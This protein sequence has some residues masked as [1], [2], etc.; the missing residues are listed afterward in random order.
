MIYKLEK[1]ILVLVC[2]LEKYYLWIVQ[3]N[4]TFTCLPSI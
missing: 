3:S 2:K 1:E 4:A